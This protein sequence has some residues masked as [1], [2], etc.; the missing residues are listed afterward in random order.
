MTTSFFFS[1]SAP[2]DTAAPNG[3][4]NSVGGLLGALLGVVEEASVDLAEAFELEE[5]LELRL[6]T[7]E[8]FL[9]VPDGLWSFCDLLELVV[10]S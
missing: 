1:S 4:E 7:H 6:D 8:L 9:L 10:E 5:N 2:G 3:L